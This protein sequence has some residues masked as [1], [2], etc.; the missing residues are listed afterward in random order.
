MGKRQW[1]FF[2]NDSK[3]MNTKSSYSVHVP[4]K[5]I[6]A[7]VFVI[8]V[9][10]C[11]NELGYSEM[12]IALKSDGAR[13]LHELRSAVAGS[14]VHPTIPIDVP[15]KE[16]KG[17]GGMERAVRTW[18][19]QY[20]SL[21]SHLEHEIKVDIPLDHV[22]LQWMAWWAANLLNRVAV[23]H[24]GRTTHEFITGH[25]MKF[26]VACFGEIFYGDRRERRQIWANT[27]QSMLKASSLV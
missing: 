4:W 21:K 9:H 5:L 14:R 7:E 17:N 20:R 24:H 18:S 23:R 8:T 1:A 25:K 6:E 12:K 3:C 10:S 13:E 19:G 27:T 15:V 26:P 22:I 16:S 2:F 11:Y